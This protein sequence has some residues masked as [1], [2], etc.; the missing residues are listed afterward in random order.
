MSFEQEALFSDLE[1]HLPSKYDGLMNKWRYC[2][3]L[4][5]KY[6]QLRQEIFDKIDALILSDM[7]KDELNC[8]FPPESI[9]FKGIALLTS[10]E[11]YNYKIAKGDDAYSTYS[12]TTGLF[13]WDSDGYGYQLT[14][15]N[16]GFSKEEANK[17]IIHHE[18]M[19][20]IFKTEYEANIKNLINVR[21]ELE[22]VTKE[23]GN[24]LIKLTKYPD[25]NNMTCEYIFPETRNWIQMLLKQI[26]R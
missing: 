15:P 12:E 23:L 16:T 11:Y 25:Y 4:I 9:F 24:N 21:N 8:K 2:R 5:K 26:T 14:P 6:C 22:Y 19:S 3:E 13:Y 20:Q 7:Q 18:N 1:N 10:K 17:I